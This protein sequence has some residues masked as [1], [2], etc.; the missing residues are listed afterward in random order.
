[1]ANRREVLQIGMAAAVLPFGAG[2]AWG[3]PPV[4]TGHEEFISVYEALYDT[5]F[6]ASRAFAERMATHGISTVAMSG[7]MTAFWSDN[8]YHRWQEG[9][10]AIAGL[11]ARGPL[12]CLERLAWDYGMRVIFRAQHSPSAAG[13]VWHE[14][15]GVSTLVDVARREASAEDWIGAMSGVVGRYPSTSAPSVRAE[16]HTAKPAVQ[17]PEDEALFSWVIAP[18]VRS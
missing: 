5:R 18:V 8:L 6:A 14:I 13:S 15:E 2:R 1:M 16:V 7:D 10:T 12:F 3:A 11:T 9:A 4:G 17:V